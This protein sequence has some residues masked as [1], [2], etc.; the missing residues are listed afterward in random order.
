[1]SND[2]FDCPQCYRKFHN[3][4]HF[5][6]HRKLCAEVEKDPLALDVTEINDKAQGV[7]NLSDQVIEIPDDEE[8][9]P[10]PSRT[11]PGGRQRGRDCYY[12]GL[13]VK[14]RIS[15]ALHLVGEHWT[16]VRERQG[17]GRMD[18]SKYYA[19]IEDSRIIKP[20]RPQTITP[21][22][23]T[24]STPRATNR[25]ERNT[26]NSF[27]GGLP[28]RRFMP[29]LPTQGYT[30]RRRILPKPPQNMAPAG[31]LWIE[32]IPDAE[33][34]KLRGKSASRGPGT[35]QGSFKKMKPNLDLDKLVKKFSNSNSN[36]QIT[37]VS[38]KS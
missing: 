7:V 36:L 4:N 30:P 25:M 38:R 35:N 8:V 13:D 20:A 17:G 31:P 19:A 28:N 26:T 10:L 1:M 37:R 5:Q 24:I 27:Y 33:F 14:D 34:K 32:K 15:L 2:Q 9:R 22:S 23:R 18:N 12:C 21:H 6:Q 16:E 3:K 29:N 11:R